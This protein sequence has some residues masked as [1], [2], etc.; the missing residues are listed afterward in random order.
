MWPGSPDDQARLFYL[1]LLLLG[2]AAFFLV[3]QRQRLS[4]SVRD[5]AIWLLIFAMVIIAYG[6]RGTLRSSLFPRSAVQL[7]AET[8]ALRRAPDGHFHAD[9]EVNGTP[10]R[11]VVDTGASEVVLSRADAD[12]VGIDTD[13]LRFTGRARTA[14]GVVATAPV[15][16]GVVRLGS[17]SD[18]D[19]PA[20]VNA[21]EL[22]ASLLGMAYL[23]RFARIE[24]AG[25]QMLLSR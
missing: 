16:L 25:D 20:R 18:L 17:F 2:I 15:R 19:V 7:S 4:R 21:G 11:F 8:I 3:G 10:V 9:V 22:D 23:D 24:I 12:R 13:T 1:V 5:L 6:F 14:N